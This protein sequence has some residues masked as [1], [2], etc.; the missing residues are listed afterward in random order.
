MQIGGLQKLT[1]DQ[2]LLRIIIFKSNYHSLLISNADVQESKY[3][4]VYNYLLY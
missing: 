3:I 4:L 2:S 1:I